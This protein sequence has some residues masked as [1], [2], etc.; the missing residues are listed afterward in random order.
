ML[1]LKNKGVADS[2]NGERGDHYVKLVVVLPAKTDPAL[3]RLVASWAEHH[4][5]TVRR[6][7]G[8]A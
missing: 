2:K 7:T 4:P 5:Y 3:E 1:R 8:V 6:P